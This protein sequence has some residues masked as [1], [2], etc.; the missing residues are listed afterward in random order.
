MKWLVS[1]LCFLTAFLLVVPCAGAQ[2]GLL[3]T[4]NDLIVDTVDTTTNAVGDLS[5][6]VSLGDATDGLGGAVSTT[7][8]TAAAVLDSGKSSTGSSAPATSGS[9][10][11][12]GTIS[13]GSGGSSRE[14]AASSPSPGKEFRSRFDRLPPRLER[15]LERIELGRNVRANLRRLQ[16]ALASLSAQDRARVLRLLNAEIR[17]LRANGVSATERK[18]IERLIRVRGAL[19]GL[20]APTSAAADASTR[21]PTTGPSLADEA[22]GASAAGGDVPPGKRAGAPGDGTRGSSSP[23]GLRAAGGFPFKIFLALGAVLLL[24]LGGLAAKEEWA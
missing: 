20:R 17:Q 18:R 11:T 24:I 19:T 12:E 15:L 22:L 7:E 6:S 13:D 3:Q 21:T 10:S 8:Q 4:S 14:S 1:Q 5:Q 16:E 23:M 2:D 9:A